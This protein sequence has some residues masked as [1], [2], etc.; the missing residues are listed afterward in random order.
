MKKWPEMSFAGNAVEWRIFKRPFKTCVKFKEENY[1]L[2]EAP[3]S[4]LKYC[5]LDENCVRRRII[6]MYSL[7]NFNVNLFRTI[8][9]VKKI[10]HLLVC[11]NFDTRDKLKLDAH[12]KFVL[13]TN[14]LYFQNEKLIRFGISCKK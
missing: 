4:Y 9:N 2:V 12:R 10:V 14:Y 1:N 5:L 7:K 8:W 13:M 6:I 11:L 3:E